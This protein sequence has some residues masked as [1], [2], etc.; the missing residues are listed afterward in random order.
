MVLKVI[1]ILEFLLGKAKG[2]TKSMI[3]RIDSSF[4]DQTSEEIFSVTI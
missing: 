2:L 3:G 4:H 1:N